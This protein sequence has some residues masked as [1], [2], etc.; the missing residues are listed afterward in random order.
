MM[1]TELLRLKPVARVMYAARYR[2]GPL[3]STHSEPGQ[4]KDNLWYDVPQQCHQRSRSTSSALVSGATACQ[5]CQ[6][7][8]VTRPMYSTDPLIYSFRDVPEPSTAET[9]TWW[10]YLRGTENGFK[11]HRVHLSQAETLAMM[12]MKMMT[13]AITVRLPKFGWRSIQE[14]AVNPSNTGHC[15]RWNQS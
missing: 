1:A 4:R 10:A 15:R 6:P 13:S 12:M 3:L 2:K 14:T 7:V 11:L 9:T 5:A 8:N